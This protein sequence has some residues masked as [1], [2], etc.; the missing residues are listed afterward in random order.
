[1]ID[2][3]FFRAILRCLHMISV[4]LFRSTQR[5]I[6]EF[7]ANMIVSVVLMMAVFAYIIYKMLYRTSTT[8]PG[9]TALPI[10]GKHQTAE[11]ILHSL[12]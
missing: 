7:V 3:Q 11:Y 4:S 6:G 10:I 8:L 2:G 5:W 12:R 9:P 1:M